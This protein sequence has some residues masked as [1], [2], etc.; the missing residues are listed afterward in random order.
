[1]DRKLLITLHLYLSAFFAPAVILVAVS[2]GLYLLGVKGNVAMEIG[3]SSTHTFNAKRS[4]KEGFLSNV[5]NPKTAVFYLAFLPQFIDPEHSPF[6]Q[7]M[8]MMGIHFVI[9]MI[10]QCGIAGMVSSAKRLF[11]SSSAMSWMEGITGTVLVFLGLKLI[12]DESVPAG[13]QDGMN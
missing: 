4:L 5:L 6:L 7:S 12:L 2:G 13:S 9:A 11:A 10:W 1:M 8:T 3:D